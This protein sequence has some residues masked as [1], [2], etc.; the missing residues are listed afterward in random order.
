M[1]RK[2]VLA[3]F[4]PFGVSLLIA[5]GAAHAATLRIAVI[6]DIPSS[7]AAIQLLDLAY[8]RLGHQLEPRPVPSRRALFMADKGIVDGDL[9]R[10]EGISAQHPNLVAVPYP[11]MRG[12]VLLVSKRDTGKCTPDLTD[13]SFTVAVRRGVIIENRAAAALADTIV[14]AESYDQIRMLLDAGRVD[15]ALVSEIEGVSPLMSQAWHETT[16]I[17]REVIPFTLYH[18]LH[19]RHEALARPLAEALAELEA[20]GEKQRILL[21]AINEGLYSR[22]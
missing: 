14:Q 1:L 21:Q 16:T 13:G 7:R 17:C 3:A 5:A 22:W 6:E 9:F 12:R 19:R 8:A 18:Y 11:L 20:S 15:A 4:V 2:A 10:I